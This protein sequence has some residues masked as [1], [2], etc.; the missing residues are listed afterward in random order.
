MNSR[1]TCESLSGTVCGELQESP[2]H[3]QTDT[4]I[5]CI[6]KISKLSVP[7][8]MVNLVTKDLK[9]KTDV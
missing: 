7:E 5:V 8:E 1:I 6:Q 2:G 4:Q 3:C 9:R